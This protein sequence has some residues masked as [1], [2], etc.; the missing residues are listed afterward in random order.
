MD[1]EKY[2]HNIHYIFYNKFVI[3]AS[4]QSKKLSPVKMEKTQNVNQ[5]KRIIS[6]NHI[7]LHIMHHK[8]QVHTSLPQ[9]RYRNKTKRFHNQHHDQLNLNCILPL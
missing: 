6:N 2:L 8:T 9:I 7:Y 5:N 4:D 1:T 3:K